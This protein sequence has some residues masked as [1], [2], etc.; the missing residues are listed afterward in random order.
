VFCEFASC[1]K[2]VTSPRL[3]QD[4]PKIVI[5]SFVNLG[6]GRIVVQQAY[7]IHIFRINSP[8]NH[9]RSSFSNKDTV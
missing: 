9:H 3:S 7:I 2:I 1:H 6:P 4:C 8:F 5:R